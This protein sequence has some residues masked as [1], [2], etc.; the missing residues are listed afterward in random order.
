[1]RHPHTIDGNRRPHPDGAS[2]RSPRGCETAALLD[3]K[4]FDALLRGDNEESARAWNALFAAAKKFARILGAGD[5][6]CIGGRTAGEVASEAAERLVLAVG[7]GRV[8]HTNLSGYLFAIVRSMLIDRHRRQKARAEED[9]DD[10]TRW[11][12]TLADTAANPEQA[13]IQREEQAL[14]Q[15]EERRVVA[16]RVRRAARAW[17]EWPERMRGVCTKRPALIRM[18]ALMTAYLRT[19]LALARTA[20]SETAAKTLADLV[21]T[22]DPERLSLSLAGLN[23]FIL[24]H[25]VSQDAKDQGWKYLRQIAAEHA[26]ALPPGLVGKSRRK[27]VSGGRIIPWLSLNPARGVTVGASRWLVP[28]APGLATPVF[29]APFALDRGERNL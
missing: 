1:M 19:E 4:L 3:D 23:T 6:R 5:D 28:W 12:E 16:R 8:Q 24:S 26:I 14:I 21:E 7:D 25:G 9:S 11:E 22:A 18:L 15:R 10:E 17:C 2:R 29:A 27:P 20:P 13:L